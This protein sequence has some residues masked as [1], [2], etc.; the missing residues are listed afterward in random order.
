[1]CFAVRTPF[2]GCPVLCCS[3]R[4]WVGPG[5]V[6]PVTHSRSAASYSHLRELRRATG[7]GRATNVTIT[8]EL[9]GTRLR[10]LGVELPADADAAL[11]QY[12]ACRLFFGAGADGGRLAFSRPRAAPAGG[13][14]E[15]PAPP[16]AAAGTPQA[17][18]LA[19]HVARAKEDRERWRELR[20]R[21]AKSSDEGESKPKA[22][23]A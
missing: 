19:Q 17:G 9:V 14:Y 4:C 2:A 8:P 3:G 21:L 22:E 6:C 1:M 10:E 18:L 20:G 5:V 11:D 15:L 23:P 12:A 16:P 13:V 7:G